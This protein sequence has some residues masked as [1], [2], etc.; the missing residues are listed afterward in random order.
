MVDAIVLAGG[1]ARRLDGADKPALTVGGRTL[2]QRVLDAVAAAERVVVVGPR[3]GIALPPHVSWCR[4]DPPGSGPVA[5]IAAGLALLTG[6]YT[7]VLAADL[8]FV[9][10]AVPVLRD[11]VRGHDVAV[12]CDAGGRANYVAAAWRRAAL[13]TALDALDSPANA[14]LRSLYA[15]VDVLAVPDGEH[16]WGTD[17]D[18][19]EDVRAARARADARGQH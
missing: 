7:L 1:P 19:W 13:A 14:A 9:A 5:A 6:E 16:G 2:L 4:E 12:L 11:A 10:G 3:P 17:C 8:P 15:G 18:T